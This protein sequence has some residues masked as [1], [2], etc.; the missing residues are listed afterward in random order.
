MSMTRNAFYG[1][2]IAFFM[3]F[4]LAC[5]ALNP[6]C[7]YAA[8]STYTVH[9][10]CVVDNAGDVPDNVTGTFSYDLCSF[11]GWGMIDV[12]GWGSYIYPSSIRHNELALYTGA[13]ATTQCKARE[14][15]KIMIQPGSTSSDRFVLTSIDIE[16]GA[17]RFT[18]DNDGK[19]SVSCTP[20]NWVQMTDRECSIVL[21]FS[22]VKDLEAKSYDYDIELSGSKQ[23]DYLGDG[24]AN[25]DT[26]RN[27]SNDYRLYLSANTG[28]ETQDDYKSKNIVF[29][30]DS[31]GSMKTALGSSSRIQVLKDSAT[32]MLNTLSQDP[33]NTYTVVS[34][35][36]DAQLLVS[37]GSAEQ[38][39]SAIRR[40]NANGGTA[41][42]DALIKAGELLQDD[43][44]E[45]VVI[46]LTDGE[47]TGVS[48]AVIG[49]PGGYTSQTPVAAAYA[50]DAAASL[51]GCDSMYAVYVG[52]DNA[53]ATW[54]QILTQKVSVS[55]DKI[56]VNARN[57]I[58]FESV[59]NQLTNRLQKPETHIEIKD[60]LSQ[61]VVYRTGSDKLVKTAADGTKS[62]LTRGTD[63]ALTY[64][65]ATKTVVATVYEKTQEHCTYVLSFDVSASVAAVRQ[66]I[67]DGVYPNTGDP[68][69]DYTV[70]G[71]GTSS[72]QAGF[73]SN[74]DARACVVWDSGERS[75][76]L[77]KPVIQVS[78][79]AD[80]NAAIKAHV[81]LY[82][83]EL[84]SNMFLYELVDEKGSVVSIAGN[85]LDG[86]IF[87]P[88]LAFDTEGEW[89]YTIRPIVPS[90]G[91][92]GWIEHME[93]D[94]S[95]FKLHVKTS[96]TGDSSGA[97]DGM[98]LDVTYE[99]DPMFYCEYSLRKTQQ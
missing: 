34:F 18:Y 68:D 54:T 23:I 26:R 75:V 4:V 93:Y 82:N 15:P 33:N 52:N 55:G 90:K 44:R 41:C 35:A 42:Y 2:L 49:G 77:A 12:N 6:S 10:T 99:S 21:H 17:S 71:N 80:S 32:R 84:S 16:S 48:Q 14:L 28:S 37:R 96:I 25:V 45:S 95:E 40:L 64:D 79:D 11:T 30:V 65:S 51:S 76:Q 50:A 73:Y 88:N 83:M 47:P 86:D 58:E 19:A 8:E 78:F 63:Y 85:N 22:Y 53:A 62:V 1:L 31:S 59:I 9:T 56:S 91:D 29:L 5:S 13:T 72:G 97:A 69:T 38:A 3:L 7:A 98:N 39:S 87:F 70:T 94:S 57:Q 81:R 89:D 74:E 67:A 43:V 24:V 60:T 92:S 27:G 46:L 66:W 36:S 61:N 20:F